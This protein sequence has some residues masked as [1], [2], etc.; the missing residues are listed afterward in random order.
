MATI[1]VVDDEPLT[2]EMLSTFLKLIGHKS[3]EAYS[4]KQAWDKLAYTEPDAILLD[5]MLPDTNGLDTCRQLRADP[6][7]ATVPIIMISAIA[8]PMLKEADQVGATAYLI[9]PVNLVNLRTTL[10]KAGVK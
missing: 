5:I 9:K 6:Q 4:S 7:W 3:I 10:E 2:A 8:P 1:L